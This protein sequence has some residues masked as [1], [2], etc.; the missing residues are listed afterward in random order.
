MVLGRR[1]ATHYSADVENPLDD[2]DS[3]NLIEDDAEQA[4]EIGRRLGEIP[5]YQETLRQMRQAVVL[6]MKRTGMSYA[7][8]GAAIDLHRNRVQQIADGSTSGGK[9]GTG[10]LPAAVEERVEGITATKPDGRTRYV[11]R[12]D[13]QPTDILAAL[14]PADIGK[15][16]L[17]TGA[18]PPIE[19]STLSRT[20]AVRAHDV[21][22]AAGLTVV[23][24][25]S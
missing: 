9:R 17:L 7:Q 22:N 20:T 16:L 24:P 15:N 14:K 1:P 8:I 5:K 11:I 18:T 2:I 12:V 19:V 10:D 23:A 4:R 21:L 13:A 25:T 3:I 6:R